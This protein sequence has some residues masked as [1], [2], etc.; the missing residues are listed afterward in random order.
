MKPRSL[1]SQGRHSLIPGGSHTY[2]RGDDTFPRNAPALLSRGRGAYV[3]DTQGRRYL[4]WAMAVRSV[5]IGHANYSIDKA[6]FALVR[7]GIN[8]SRPTPEEFL[9]ADRISG[10]IPGA[11][12]V[13]FGKNGSDATA[14]AIRLARSATG[15]DLVLRSSQAAF[16]GVHDWFIGS[17]VMDAGIPRAV[18]ELTRIFPYGD[19]GGLE[20][21]L[22]ENSG[23][24]AAVILEPL[25]QEVP[26][27]GYL[28]QLVEMVRS[29]GAVVIFDEVVSGFRVGISG[30]Q[31]VEG[32]VPDLSAFGKAIA[33][34]YPF[35]ALVG[36]AA[37]MELGG[38]LH[39][40]NRTFIMSSTYG[41]ERAS[42]GA[43]LATLDFMEKRNPFVANQRVMASLVSSLRADI[44]QQGLES[45]VSIT[46]LEISPN[47]GFL[48]LDGSSS[49]VLKTAFM[50]Q[51]LTHGILTGNHLFSVGACHRNFELS[52]TQRA[53]SASM[54][55]IKGNI[56]RLDATDDFTE[57]V[58]RP[59][60][61]VKN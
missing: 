10:L 13:K 6:A 42:I 17:T 3:W 31:G 23:K 19:I 1:S 26:P 11:E 54:A 52:R 7:K 55:F 41:P 5:S 49:L 8:L 40:R 44:R 60:F 58:I 25:G 18:A 36:K 30:Y 34:G 43:A 50:E 33:N 12:M 2:S 48:K 9:L 29:H 39:N 27:V 57:G 15:R 32:V 21:I 14:A 46:G 16:L 61:R 4:D 56:D 59:V 47:I 20:K 35:S 37:L 24:V 22:N 28:H 38:T 53:V 45:R 51:M